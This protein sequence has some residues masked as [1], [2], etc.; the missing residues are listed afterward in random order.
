M[1]HSNVQML[2]MMQQ[3]NTNGTLRTGFH[4]AVLTLTNQYYMIGFDKNIYLYLVLDIH[5]NYYHIFD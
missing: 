1:K 3:S 2:N 5:R 4:L